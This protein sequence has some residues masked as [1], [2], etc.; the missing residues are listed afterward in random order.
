[1]R[2]TLKQTQ[3]IDFLEDATTTELLFGGAAGGGKSVLGCYWLLKSSLKYPG[4]RWMMGRSQLQQLKNTTLKTFFDVC[5]IQGLQAG[6]HFEYVQTEKLIKF[7]NES[8]IV[9]ADLYYYPRDPDFDSLGSLEITGAF[10]DEC[11][12]IV[13]KAKQIVLSRMRYKLKEYNLKAKL[14]MTCNPAK[15]W[16]YTE[17]YK[18]FKEGKLPNERKF[19]QSLISD[20]EHL[21]EEY[22][23]LLSRLDKPSR[24]RLLQGLWEYDEDPSALMDYDSITAI[25][26]NTHVQPTG[27]RYMSVDVA[28]FGDDATKIRLWDG[29]KV[30]HKVVMFKKSTK[31]VADMLKELSKNY[32]IP[33]SN[34]VID[35][36]GIGGG[37]VDQFLGTKG[38]IANSKPV[39]CK[40]GEVYENFKSQCAFKLAELVKSKSIFEPETD[41]LQQE[42]LIEDLEQIKKKNLDKQSKAGIIPKDEVKV[43]IGRSPDDG[44]TYIMRM[45]F[46]VV[47]TG[48]MRVL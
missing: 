48:A 46:E 35:E 6:V 33:P 36:D 34:I 37:V 40:P 30:F 31:E 14:L 11:S 29:L 43:V 39:N 26:T 23:Q 9:L 10:I 28:R 32:Q 24:Q 5:K 15:K 41:S 12:Q 22:A 8:Q 44:D 25:F 1:M 17:F 19:I 3:A 20:N 27:K 13:G 16:P 7:N 2:L 47:K 38:F 4:T 42:I 18:P 21:P 45:Y